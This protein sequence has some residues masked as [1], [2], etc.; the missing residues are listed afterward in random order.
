ML[1]PWAA[2]IAGI[3]ATALATAVEFGIQ[4]DLFHTASGVPLYSHERGPRRT[5]PGGHRDAR[6]Y[7]GS[8]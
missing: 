4:P 1:G 7:P 3:N 5:A 8:G 6:S 2:V